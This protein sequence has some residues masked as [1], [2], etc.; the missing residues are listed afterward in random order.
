M[1][2]ETVREIALALPQVEEGT[3]YGTPALR[4]RGK[5]LARLREDGESLV[6]HVDPF[7]RDQL[8]SAHP[9]TYYLTDHYR[10][11]PYILVRLLSAENEA[12]RDLLEEAWRLQAP[13]RLVAAHARRSASEGSDS[14]LP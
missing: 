14:T 12:V 11:Y 13:K 6:L 2:Y 5:L 4:V 7:E 10:P 9:E 1:N 3:C 8:L